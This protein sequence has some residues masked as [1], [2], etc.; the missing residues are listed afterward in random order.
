MKRII[1]LLLVAALVLSLAGC[2]MVSDRVL[3]VEKAIDEIGE[4]T[5]ESADRIAEARKAFDRLPEKEKKNVSNARKLVAAEEELQDLKNNGTVTELIDALWALRDIIPASAEE[6]EKL[7]ARLDEL[8][9]KL[10]DRVNNSGRLEDAREVLAVSETIEALGDILPALKEVPARLKEAGEESLA[11]VPEI[12]AGAKES[13]D[14]ALSAFDA[15]DP[16]LQR[17]LGNSTLLEDAKD[18][19]Q[20]A[21]YAVAEKH[22]GEWEMEKA[23]ELYRQFPEDY[24]ETASRIASAEN[25]LNWQ[26]ARA[27]L[28][29]KWVW[30]GQTSAGSDGKTYRADFPELTI[31]ELQPDDAFAGIRFREKRLLYVELVPGTLKKAELSQTVLIKLH[32][33]RPKSFTAANIE[34]YLHLD[35]HLDGGRQVYSGDIPTDT[36]PWEGARLVL[37]GGIHTHGTSGGSSWDHLLQM[38]ITLQEDG[39]LRVEYYVRDRD[40]VTDPNALPAMAETV[41]FYYDKK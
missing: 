41:V 5:L 19:Y 4:V 8:P 2:G 13:I 33:L 16:E 12:L 20:A 35:D 29:G 21:Q 15:L 6:I 37:H 34:S 39:R 10:R 17:M 14:E 7:Q 22:F 26:A 3:A 24:K 25:F 27:D 30:D 36:G 9:Q 1:C 31:R 32:E 38:T 11:D 23:L 40:K 18:W 28:P